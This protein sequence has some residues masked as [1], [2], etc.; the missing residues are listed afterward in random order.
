MS[1]VEGYWYGQEISG[2]N[3]VLGV[4]K[5]W[6]DR[7]ENVICIQPQRLENWDYIGY[8]NFYS[9]FDKT[10]DSMTNDMNYRPYSRG[11][12]GYSGGSDYDSGYS[13]SDYSS[14]SSSS[15]GGSSGG[16]HAGGGGSSW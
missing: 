9:A 12:S 13:S 4:S 3:N 2:N 1:G 6:T 16:G 7:F 11:R 8:S 5:E 14:S 15:G 10:V